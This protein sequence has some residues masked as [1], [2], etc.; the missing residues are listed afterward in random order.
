MAGLEKF[1]TPGD[2]TPK[3]QRKSEKQR[4]GDSLRR[5]KG[6]GKILLQVTRGR[7]KGSDSL[8]K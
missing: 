3:R 1:T 7:D 5:G 6:G 2:L 8:K 4:K